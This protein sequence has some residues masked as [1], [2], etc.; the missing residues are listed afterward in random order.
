MIEVA[1]VFDKEGR[2]IFW[3][4]TGTETSGSIPDDRSLWDY[5][6]ENRERIGGVAHTHPWSG[7]AHPSHTDLTTYAAIEAGLGKRLCWPVVTMTEVRYFGYADPAQD[8]EEY[9]PEFAV[10]EAW[11]HGI[12]EMR[13]LSQGG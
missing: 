9:T 11:L 5:I 2:P 3:P 7:E 10:N 4:S 1:M 12:N 8:Y 6:W 13:R